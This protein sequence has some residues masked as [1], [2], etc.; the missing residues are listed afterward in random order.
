M[1]YPKLLIK[2]TLNCRGRVGMT[3]NPTDPPASEDELS[4]CKNGCWCMTKTIDSKCGKCGAPKEDAAS[5]DGLREKLENIT[6]SVD[7]K[8]DGES[9]TVIVSRLHL[10]ADCVDDLMQAFAKEHTRL[11]HEIKGQ[12]P[13]KL[14]DVSAPETCHCGHRHYNRD[15]PAKLTRNAIIDQ[16]QAVLYAE[17]ARLSGTAELLTRKPVR[18]DTGGS[19]HKGTGDG[20]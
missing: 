12:M 15:D 20:E 11:L 2:L 5:E 6:F 7:T 19:L 8:D 18:K 3:D 1:N 13:N 4:L 17:I 16:V 9:P 14:T 10:P